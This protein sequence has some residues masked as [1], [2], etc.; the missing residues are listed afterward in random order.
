MISLNQFGFHKF[1]QNQTKTNT[2]WQAARV[3]TQERN[4]FRLMT[5]TG[6][7]S[8]HLAG[9]FHKPENVFKRPV[10]GDW[11]W[12]QASELDDQARVEAVFERSSCLQRKSAQG[13]EQQVIAANVDVVFLVSSLNRDLNARRLER[14]LAAIRNSGA[15][16]VLILNKVDLLAGDDDLLDLLLTELEWTAPGTPVYAISAMNG[17]GVEALKAHINQDSTVVLIGSSGVGKSTLT[18]ALLGKPAQQIQEIR[19]SDDRGRHT[20]TR[21]DLFP[22]PGGGCLIDTPGMREFTLWE[23]D[24]GDLD[25]TFPEIQAA[26]ERCR[27]RD[28]RHHSEPGCGVQEALEAGTILE[29]RYFSYLKLQREQQRLNKKLKKQAWFAE[30]K[31]KKRAIKKENRRMRRKRWAYEA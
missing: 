4:C 29:E 2:N 6:E 5:A 25:Q 21:R 9:H 18:N 17:Q 10:V 26:M 31:E 1:F 7:R 16:A 27:F 12:I 28:C 22:I 30:H 8:G 20:T 24:E 14:Y 23:L 13:S 11:V 3:L 19:H 15:E